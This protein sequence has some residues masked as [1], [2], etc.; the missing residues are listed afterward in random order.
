MVGN[1]AQTGRE[2]G[3]EIVEAVFANALNVALIRIFH[4]DHV[5][6][7]VTDDRLQSFQ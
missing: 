4:V 5:L 6:M 7:V 2:G 3:K 1:I